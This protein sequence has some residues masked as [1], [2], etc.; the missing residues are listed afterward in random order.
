LVA[1][2]KEDCLSF[3]RNPHTS[4]AAGTRALA[5]LSL[6]AIAFTRRFTR[7]TNAF[8]KEG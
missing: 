8:S 3:K 5:P 1:T 4:F 6:S 2:A 7:L